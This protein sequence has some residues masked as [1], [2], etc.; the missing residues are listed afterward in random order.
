MYGIT[1]NCATRYCP[2]GLQIIP[3]SFSGSEYA[4]IHL[5]YR[6][7]NGNSRTIVEAY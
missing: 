3:F 5:I 4:S 7:Y 1:V 2:R 6:Y